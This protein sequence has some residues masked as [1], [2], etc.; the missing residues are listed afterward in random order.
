MKK[1]LF[2]IAGI[3][4]IKSLHY[5]SCS[6]FDRNGGGGN[7]LVDDTVGAGNLY[8]QYSLGNYQ[9]DFFVDSSWDWLPWNWGMA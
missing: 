5:F 8:S 3:L 4:T 1:K 2:R 9:L 6:Q 7:S